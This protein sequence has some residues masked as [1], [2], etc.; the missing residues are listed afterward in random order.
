[1]IMGLFSKPAP[2]Q[3]PKYWHT[4]PGEKLTK[5]DKEAGR[6][7]WLDAPHK[8]KQATKDQSGRK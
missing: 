4:R 8:K 6:V 2:V 7:S 1:M 5:K 3:G